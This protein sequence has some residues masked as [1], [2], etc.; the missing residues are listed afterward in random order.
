MFLART[1]MAVKP[2]V[3]SNHDRLSL[4]MALDRALNV[5]LKKLTDHRLRFLDIGVIR[6][7]EISKTFLTDHTT[8]SP[9]GL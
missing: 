6:F 8:S 3:H 2:I 5:A 4:N 1:L 9:A 7:V